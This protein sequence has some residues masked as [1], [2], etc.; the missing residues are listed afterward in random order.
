MKKRLKQYKGLKNDR[1]AKQ[2]EH[3]GPQKNSK[4][5]QLS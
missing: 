5:R 3:N 1:E 4:S 2:Q